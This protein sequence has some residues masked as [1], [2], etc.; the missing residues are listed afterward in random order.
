MGKKIIYMKTKT[1]EDFMKALLV[2]FLLLC[3][4]IAFAEDSGLE[5]TMSY[6]STD[7]FSTQTDSNTEW[8]A[9]GGQMKGS[10]V[11]ADKN[12]GW[13]TQAAHSIKVAKNKSNWNVTILNDKKSAVGSFSFP[14]RQGMKATVSV[15]AFMAN[16]SEDSPKYNKLEVSCHFTAFAG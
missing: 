15:E 3:S 1:K 5:C 14:E 2:S 9:P 13:S 8:L 16:E 12:G 4:S 7:V 11:A 10:A 6:S